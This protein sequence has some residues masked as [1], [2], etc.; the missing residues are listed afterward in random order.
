MAREAAG[1]DLA[2]LLGPGRE[3]DPGRIPDAFDVVDRVVH[4]D[5]DVVRIQPGEA[6]FEVGHHLVRAR[7]G[8]EDGL[9]R[10]RHAIPRAR[11]RPTERPLGLAVRVVPRGVEM[12]DAQIQGMPDAVLVA[13]QAE[14]PEADVG[15]LHAGPAQR[16][17][18]P[19]PRAIVVGRRARP[20]RQQRNGETHPG[21]SYQELSSAEIA[22]PTNGHRDLLCLGRRSTGWSLPRP[23]SEPESARLHPPA[24]TMAPTIDRSG[25]DPLERDRLGSSIF[26]SPRIAWARVARGRGGCPDE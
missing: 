13:V 14:G 15:D 3:L 24:Q 5:V 8:A 18:T 25:D 6:S 21:A 19:D 17:T 7:V 26:A 22:A 10:D 23:A 2:L 11:Q 1:P 12:R 16:R 9:G 4:E 20:G